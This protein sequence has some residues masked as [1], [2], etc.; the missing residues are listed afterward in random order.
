VDD[1]SVLGLALTL[2]VGNVPV[3]HALQISISAL[4]VSSFVVRKMF[5]PAVVDFSSSSSSLKADLTYIPVIP[6]SYRL[7][8]TL[9]GPSSSNYRVVFPAGDVLEWRR[10]CL[11]PWCNDQ[12]SLQMEAR[13]KS[14][15]H[16]Q[17]TVVV[18]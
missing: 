7:N 3:D 16:P 4:E 17:P 14:L 11:L 15:S 5:A 2:D 13:S 1:D 18:W 9:G 10:S 12:S 8:V 6:G